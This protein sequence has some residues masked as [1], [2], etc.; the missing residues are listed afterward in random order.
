MD[1][2]ALIARITEEQLIHELT[3]PPAIRHKD[4]KI[5]ELI[6]TVED[7]VARIEALE[8]SEQK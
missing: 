7:L 6:Y 1:N 5:N 4:P 8:R 3:R 2:E